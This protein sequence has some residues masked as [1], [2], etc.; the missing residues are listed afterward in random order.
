MVAESFGNTW[1]TECRLIVETGEGF[2]DPTAATTMV[3]G[4]AS[5]IVDG[6]PDDGGDDG[7]RLSVLYSLYRYDPN[8]LG[9]SAVLADGPLTVRSTTPFG[10]STASD[11]TLPPTPV[12]FE[13]PLRDVPCMMLF[14][15][16][17]LSGTA[18]GRHVAYIGESA[19]ACRPAS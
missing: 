15:R 17:T 8:D 13:I 5:L 2:A 19:E 11:P 4:A 18:E 3:T 10:Y 14:V 6:F 1:P 16:W 9:A 12:S 7:V